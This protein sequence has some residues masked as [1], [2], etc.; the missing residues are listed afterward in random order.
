MIENIKVYETS[1][2]SLIIF[3]YSSVTKLIE[4]NTYCCKLKSF[5]SDFISLS[6]KL[7]YLKNFLRRISENYIQNT[8]FQFRQTFYNRGVVS[9]E[10]ITNFKYSPYFSLYS[11]RTRSI[12]SYRNEYLLSSKRICLYFTQ[13]YPF[14]PNL[15]L[16]ILIFQGDLSPKRITFIF[17]HQFILIYYT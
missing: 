6:V 17:R 10:F 16:F 1:I 13:I 2:G 8:S 3:Y 5:T 7:I 15:S 11:V 4:I 9:Y 12:L 14:E